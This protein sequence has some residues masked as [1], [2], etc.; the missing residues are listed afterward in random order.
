MLRRNEGVDVTEQQH[1]LAYAE[2]QW[3]HYRLRALAAQLD[4]Q[5]ALAAGE[6]GTAKDR[7]N[8]FRRYIEHMAD[9]ND[10]LDTLRRAVAESEED[11]NRRKT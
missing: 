7:A 9:C 3:E 10:T 6:P 1:Q 2:R 4:A 5:V 8:V 11:M